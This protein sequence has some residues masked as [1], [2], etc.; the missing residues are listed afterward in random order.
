MFHIH[1]IQF[2]FKATRSIVYFWWTCHGHGLVNSEKK[3][4]WSSESACRISLNIHINFLQLFGMTYCL[5]CNIAQWQIIIHYVHNYNNLV[6]GYGYAMGMAKCSGGR[7]RT[8]PGVFCQQL[9]HNPAG[10]PIPIG[11]EIVFLPLPSAQHL[12]AVVPF[13]SIQ[14]NNAIKPSRQI[15]FSKF[16]ALG[17]KLPFNI[18]ATHEE[19]I[20]GSQ[21]IGTF[22]ISETHLWWNLL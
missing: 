19:I 16:K 22:E 11:I 17:W 12:P 6:L 18:T 10:P 13:L 2:H 8:G 1:D 7:P 4:W 14:M 9:L 20:Q 21:S 5:Q 3:N 15:L